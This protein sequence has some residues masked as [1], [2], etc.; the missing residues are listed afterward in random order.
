MGHD[1][2]GSQQCDHFD[3]EPWGFHHHV[4]HLE[5]FGIG[6]QAVDRAKKQKHQVDAEGGREQLG[7]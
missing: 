6:P 5:A 7:Q 3:H 1:E 2:E 4:H